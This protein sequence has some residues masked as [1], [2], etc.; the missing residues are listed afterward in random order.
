MR[1][2]FAIRIKMRILNIWNENA[3]HYEILIWHH[4]KPTQN[5][6]FISIAFIVPNQSYILANPTECI[7]NVIWKLKSD[8]ALMETKQIKGRIQLP[9][10]WDNELEIL[11][12]SSEQITFHFDFLCFFFSSHLFGYRKWMGFNMSLYRS[13]S[14]DN[15]IKALNMSTHT[16]TYTSYQLSCCNV[17]IKFEK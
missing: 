14:R 13:I 1:A 5:S 2:D 4:I 7:W 10:D 12:S 11:S 8:M 3:H 17:Q 15:I 9:Q 16:H 6:T